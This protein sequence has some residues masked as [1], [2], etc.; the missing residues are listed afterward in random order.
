MR[1]I[2]G[3]IKTGVAGNGSLI[4]EISIPWVNNSSIGATFFN[5]PYKQGYAQQ[6][7]QLIMDKVD[8]VVNK[9]RT[10]WVPYPARAL[11]YDIP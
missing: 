5:N 3:I 4:F 11:I 6:N 8:Y 7:L 9:A 10:N 1:H 2:R